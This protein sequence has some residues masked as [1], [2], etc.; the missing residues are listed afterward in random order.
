MPPPRNTR[1][2]N[3]PPSYHSTAE[4]GRGQFVPGQLYFSTEEGYHYSPQGENQPLFSD[5]SEPGADA[6]TTKPS[7]IFGRHLRSFMG[8]MLIL[9]VGL[10]SA[11]IY[12]NNDQWKETREQQKQKEREEQR[13]LIQWGSLKK[14]EECLSYGIARY[15]AHLDYVP[16]LWDQHS[17]CLETP[18]RVHEKDVLPTRCD[19]VNV[20]L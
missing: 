9:I 2:G 5:G 15:Q 18:A 7:G 16:P 12:A 14:D 17:A 1:R 19:R 11:Y 6:D 20:S 4:S 3:L 8:I 13:G 10:Q